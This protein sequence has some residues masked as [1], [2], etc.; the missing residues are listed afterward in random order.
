MGRKGFPQ[1]QLDNLDDDFTSSTINS[2]ME[3]HKLGKPSNIEELRKRIDY[4]F[5]FCAENNLRPGIENLCLALH[6][7]RTTLFNWSR[8][9][10]CEKDWA[11]CIIQAK[12]FISAFLE[13]SV[14]K[15]KI[16]PPSGIFLMK[17][18]MDYK[19]Q[20]SFET[21]TLTKDP[22]KPSRSIEEIKAEFANL[23]PEGW[24]D[25]ELEKPVL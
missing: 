13:Q 5:Q 24:E 3:L 16:S 4:F 6:V 17:N 22:N 1:Q 15:G 9:I 23:L 12:S 14:T 11:E 25:E 21:T 7:T 10:G 2:L 19:D 20:M 18:W 8:E